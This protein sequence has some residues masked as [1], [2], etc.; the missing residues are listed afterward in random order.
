[1]SETPVDVK[2]VETT[3]PPPPP[4]TPDTALQQERDAERNRFTREEKLRRDYEDSQRIINAVK[5][6]GW[7]LDL[8]SK[9]APKEVAKNTTDTVS[10]D[11][12]LKLKEEMEKEKSLRYELDELQSIVDFTK[13]SGKYE[14]ISNLEDGV[15]YVQQAIKDHHRNTGKHISYEEACDY[16]EDIIEK[17]E[18]GRY[19]K[20]SKTAKAEKIYNL[21]KS[22][23]PAKP[24]PTSTNKSKVTAKEPSN[25]P[26]PKD[27]QTSNSNEAFKYFC[28]KYGL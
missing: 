15:K 19:E 23:S 25:V 17:Q 5:K 11:E 7:D 3:P 16:V 20:F 8:L 10:K 14:L 21:K 1:M 22:D 13:K 2:V 18:K 6:Q 26:E 4:A 9:Q 24:E 28:K 27:L 12:F